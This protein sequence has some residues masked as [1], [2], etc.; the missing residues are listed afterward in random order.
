MWSSIAAAVRPVALTAC[1]LFSC[2]IV[3]W[4][5]VVSAFL[6][7]PSGP[8]AAVS[9]RRTLT[10]RYLLCRS[11]SSSIASSGIGG[12][13]ARRGVLMAI[14][15]VDV[16]VESDVNSEKESEEV[17]KPDRDVESQAYQSAE[18]WTLKYHDIKTRRDAADARAKVGVKPS[19]LDGYLNETCSLF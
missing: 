16:G 15:Q 18:G 9:S 14:G 13:E 7:P 8:P 19:L 17:Y 3:N 2:N 6:V 11:S 1:L 5:N 12:G 4:N 10:P